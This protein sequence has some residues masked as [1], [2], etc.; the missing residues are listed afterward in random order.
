M[1]L[2]PRGAIECSDNSGAVALKRSSPLA[3]PV[4]LLAKW[5]NRDA[6]KKTAPSPG[7]TPFPYSVQT[8][9]F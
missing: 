5:R 8:E 3:C 9:A 2:A 1:T 4:T 7:T 6:M